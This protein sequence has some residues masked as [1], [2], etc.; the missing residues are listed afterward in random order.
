[1]VIVQR[2]M[3]ALASVTAPLLVPL[4]VPELEPEP[5]EPA[6]ELVPDPLDAPPEPDAAPL[7]EPELPLA[8][9]PPLAPP[10]EEVPSFASGPAGIEL[11]PHPTATTLASA[12]SES[13]ARV[14]RRMGSPPEAVGPLTA[15]NSSRILLREDKKMSATREVLSN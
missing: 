10:L 8:P 13:N 15:G 14:G 1:M 3:G 4:L 12:A 6:P 11:L 2:P 7:A 5:L 9:D